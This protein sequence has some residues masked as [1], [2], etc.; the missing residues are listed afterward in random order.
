MPLSNFPSTKPIRGFG[1][2]GTPALSLEDFQITLHS[3]ENSRKNLKFPIILVD[4]PTLRKF[5][6][7]ALNNAL[8][9]PTLIGLDFLEMNNMKLFID[10]KNDIAYL[11]D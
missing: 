3:A 1:R 6:E 11:E 9:I 5:G 4:V 2:G 8:T 10:I 7:D